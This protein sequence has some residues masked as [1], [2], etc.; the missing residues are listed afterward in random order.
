MW[1][2]LPGGFTCHVKELGPCCKEWH[3][4]QNVWNLEWPQCNRWHA[5][6]DQ[7]FAASG[8]GNPV[9]EGKATSQT[10]WHAGGG[11]C[12]LQSYPSIADPWP[13]SRNL[14][15]PDRFCARFP[16]LNFSPSTCLPHADVCSACLGIS[17]FTP[18][19]AAWPA[20]WDVGRGNGKRL[21]LLIGLRQLDRR[22]CSSIEAGGP[23]SSQGHKVSMW[24][25]LYFVSFSEIMRG[26]C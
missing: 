21:A 7:S 19:R 12:L 24:V 25:A 5:A 18:A 13:S 11:H 4:R 10:C 1:R 14:N 2:W 9:E 15:L 3:E 8:R 20:K 17:A 16:R 23:R 26:H 22:W 6:G